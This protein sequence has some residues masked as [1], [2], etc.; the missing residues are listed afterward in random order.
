M[1]AALIAYKRIKSFTHDN[2]D[3]DVS[4]L[5]CNEKFKTIPDIAVDATKNS[6]FSKDKAIQ[7]VLE[8]CK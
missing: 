1:S 7:K 3:F 4:R 6:D 2:I 5:E 8:S